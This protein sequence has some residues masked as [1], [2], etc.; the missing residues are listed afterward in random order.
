MDLGESKA[1]S[2]IRLHPCSDDFGGIGNGFGFPVRF[3]LEVSDDPGFKSSTLVADQTADDYPNLGIAY[4]AAAKDVTGRYIR[5]TATKLYDR[6]GSPMFA[7]SELQA[8]S[9]EG[10]N[11]ALNKVVSSSTSIEAPARWARKNLTDGKL[12]LIHI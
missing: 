2:E 4:Y 6:N 8:L 9:A 3:K 7:M 1:I 12:S 11:L 10:T 5:L